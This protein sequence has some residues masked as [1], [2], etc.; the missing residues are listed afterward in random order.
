[1][2]FSKIKK[3]LNQSHGF[4]LIEVVL[5]LALTG[6][7]FLSIYSLYA[8]TLRY[9]TES[10]YEVIA[11]NLAQEGAEIIR[12]IRDDN[13]LN[14]EAINYQLSQG[15]CQPFFSGEDPSC[16]SSSR[17]EA[18]EIIDDHYENCQTTCSTKTPFK[19]V[20]NIY[21]ANVSEIKFSC[22]VSWESF[23]INSERSIVVEGYLTNWQ[24]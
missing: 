21:T 14:E 8:V 7:V 18:V 3:N 9:D 2:K 4:S 6:L 17:I 23:A 1:M 19:R 12:N 20:C 15:S 11:S 13:F 10:R 24:D 16:D 5:S 22:T